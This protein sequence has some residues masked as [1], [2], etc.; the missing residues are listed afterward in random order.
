M[1]VLI[2]RSATGPIPWTTKTKWSISADSPV[3][4]KKNIFIVGNRDKYLT[5]REIT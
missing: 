5:N 2:F 4:K 1:I 3:S